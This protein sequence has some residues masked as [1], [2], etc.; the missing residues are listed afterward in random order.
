MLNSK[1]DIDAAG[2]LGNDLAETAYLKQQVIDPK[3]HFFKFFCS[4][5]YYIILL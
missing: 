3:N 1:N 2:L 5:C 4:F